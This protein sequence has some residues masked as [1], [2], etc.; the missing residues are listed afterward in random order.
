MHT[1]HKDLKDQWKF[2][3]GERLVSTRNTACV[4]CPTMLGLNGAKKLVHFF[5]V[6]GLL[7][8]DGLYKILEAVNKAVRNRSQSQ[9]RPQGSFLIGDN[10]LFTIDHLALDFPP[11]LRGITRARGLRFVHQLSIISCSAINFRS[12]TLH[13]GVYQTGTAA[14]AAA[15]VIVVPVRQLQPAKVVDS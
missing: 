9:H 10:T 12:R 5:Q 8:S 11:N 14:I 7:L 2:A 6:V 4:F 1:R 15:V 13:N 3:D